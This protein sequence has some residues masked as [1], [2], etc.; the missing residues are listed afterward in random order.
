MGTF[1]QTRDRRHARVYCSCHDRQTP[2]CRMSHTRLRPHRHGR[3]PAQVGE[4]VTY[5]RDMYDAAVGADALLLLTEWKEFRLPSWEAI[6][7]LMH[8]RLLIDGR[9]IYD[10]EELSEAGFQYHCIGK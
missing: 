7:R 9:N 8:H 4:H 10:A 5:C 6:G 1:F 2:P 3:M